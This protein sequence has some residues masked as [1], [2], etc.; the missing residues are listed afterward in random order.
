LS[1]AGKMGSQI[2]CEYPIGGHAVTFAAPHPESV[3]ARIGSALEL[4]LNVG[5]L[6]HAGSV[7]EQVAVRTEAPGGFDLIVES[8]PEDFDLNGECLRAAAASPRA[9][10]ATNASSLSITALGAAI[11]RPERTLGTHYW[12]PPLLMPLVEVIRGSDTSPECATQVGDLLSAIGKLP[13]AVDRDIPG[14][15]WNRL[16]PT[17][18]RED[19]WLV[20]NGVASPD[21]RRHDNPR[22]ARPP[23]DVAPD[24]R[25]FPAGVVRKSI[26]DGLERWC[27]TRTPRASP[28][29]APR[30]SPTPCR[31]PRPTPSRAT[32]V[33]SGSGAGAFT[34]HDGGTRPD[35]KT[36]FC[37]S[38]GLLTRIVSPTSASR[39]DVE[40]PAERSERPLTRSRTRSST[41]LAFPGDSG[42]SQRPTSARTSAATRRRTESSS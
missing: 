23:L 41:N 24:R 17:L 26:F 32:A 2:G 9:T 8:M 4:A 30:C 19:L 13:V 22:R 27:R 29:R 3:W 35:H 18:L 34:I 14:F 10:V 12:D 5:T 1:G 28:G 11:G 40:Q 20:E 37:N 15:V 31:P 7:R 38:D 6:D 39:L 16:Q 33:V 25:E 21:T 36:R 42:P